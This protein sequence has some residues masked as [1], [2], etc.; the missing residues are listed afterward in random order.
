MGLKKYR[1]AL[2]RAAHSGI[3]KSKAKMGG[4][5]FM[6][7]KFGTAV[8]LGAA[9]KNSKGWF[10][11]S[12]L[13]PDTIGFGLALLSYGATHVFFKKYRRLSE[14]VLEGAAI[15]MALGWVYRSD[16]QF[17]AGEDGTVRL[18]GVGGAP[19]KRKPQTREEQPAA[20]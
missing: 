10:G 13:R 1:A 11:I 20:E 15:A 16:F 8:T 7:A 3:A 2:A 12:G 5:G 9:S 18:A 19:K 4:L 14:V 6:I 17:I